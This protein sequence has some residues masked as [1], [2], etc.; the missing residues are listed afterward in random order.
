MKQVAFLI[1]GFNL[2]HSIEDIEFS[3]H[4]CFKWLNLHSLCQSFMY[5]FGREYTLHKIFFFTA[6]AYHYMDLQKVQRH[7]DYIKCLESTGIEVI[8]GR[9]KEK[10]E[11][12]PLCKRV[13]TG[14]VE[15]EPD[16]AFCSKLLELL[17][18]ND[19]SHCEA[20]VLVTGD[21]DLVPVIKTVQRVYPST[22]I[23][24][25]FPYNRKSEDLVKLVPSSF[26][27]RTGHYQANQFKS[28]VQLTDGTL[29][30]KPTSW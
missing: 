19:D 15:K 22:D 1:D 2:Y 9:F 14:H 11:Y 13:Y 16:I 24:F 29:I 6:I 7:G 17:Y 4:I 28:P 25:A 12:C 21:S 20:F 8:R 10:T 27:L 26:K 3:K 18:A 30:H 23:R 5:L